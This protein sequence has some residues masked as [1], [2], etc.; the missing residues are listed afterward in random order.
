MN[1]TTVGVDLAKETIQVC[2]VAANKVLM[3]RDM[4][5]KQFTRWLATHKPARVIFEACATSNYWQQRALEAGHDARLISAKLVAQVRQNQK[6]D[7]NDA[8]AIVQASQLT[9]IQYIHGKTVE[10]QELQTLMRLRELSVKQRQALGQQLEA[11]L[12]EFNI[13]VSAK[14]GGLSAVVQRVL[15]DADNGFA[16][17]FRSA[18]HTAWQAYLSMTTHIREYTRSLKQAIEDHDECKKLLALEGV[19]EINAVN[20]YIALGCGEA[21]VFNTGRDAA[22]CLG[23]TPTQYSSGG[24][25]QL[26]SI[27]KF[28]K[29]GAIR[30]HLIVGAMAVVAQV[31]KREPRTAKEQWLKG[32]AERRGKKC[33]AV[34]L[35]NK[36]VRT[37]FAMLNN[38][39]LYSAQPLAE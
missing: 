34:A 20:L 8:L 39:T 5:P 23:V 25:T 29:K 2:Q 6:T 4:A 19:G 32:L 7:K 9:G 3:N 11:L 38:G 10:Q 22:A 12:L 37:A 18:L 26:G 17:P 14:A 31:V 1:H 33:A 27:K 30:S 16:A 15:E 28:V 24:K 13:R 35:A 36:T 21:G